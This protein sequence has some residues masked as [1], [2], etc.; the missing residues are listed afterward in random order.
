MSTGGPSAACT[1]TGT[2]YSCTWN[3]GSLANGNYTITVTAKDAANNGNSTSVAVT[4]NN[5][6]DTTAPNV[7][8][9]SPANGAIV[10]G[11]LTINAS[12]SDNVG[13]TSVSFY[14]GAN[15]ICTDSAPPFSC[16]WN[17]SGS[18]NGAHT[19]SA[20]A[21]DAANNSTTSSVNLTVDNSSPTVSF[22]APR[23]GESIVAGQYTVQVNASDNLRLTL[24]ELF[25]DGAR[26]ASSSA[27]SSTGTLSYKWSTAKAK[28]SHS[29][30]ARSTDVAGNVSTTASVIVTVK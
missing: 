3:A 2:N 6:G 22:V 1:L 29:L 26:V 28:G 24:I 18:S 8:V 14:D 12:A 21:K 4:L 10:A 13:V 7:S 20:T 23:N 5:G 25:I 11:T 30:T 16:T 17:S 27:S 9:D 15:L 19:I